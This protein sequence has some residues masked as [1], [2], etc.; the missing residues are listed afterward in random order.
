MEN[1]EQNWNNNAEINKWKSYN[2]TKNY[3]FN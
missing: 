1:N 2:P 3:I